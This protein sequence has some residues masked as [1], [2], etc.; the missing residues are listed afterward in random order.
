MDL[1]DGLRSSPGLLLGATALLGLLVG[2]F[3][4][5]VILR[6][7]QMMELAWR[8]E[9]RSLLALDEV[10]EPAISLTKPASRCPGCGAAIKPW[11]NVPVVSWLLQW[12]IAM[13][14]V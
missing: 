12:Q 14:C 7:P 8:R 1:I 4:N 13:K 10:D 11:Q 2:S 9:A 6:L 3:L 5:V